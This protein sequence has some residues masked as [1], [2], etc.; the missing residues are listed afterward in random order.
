MSLLRRLLACLLLLSL[1]ACSA[2]TAYRP[3]IV[4]QH[5]LTLAYSDGV[6]I[7]AGRELLTEAPRFDGLSEYVHCVP[8]AV[9]HAEDAESAGQAATGLA[10]T[11][12][13]LGAGS[14]GGLSGL[15]FI[16]DEPATGYAILGTGIGVALIGLTMA[17]VSRAS[18]NQANGHAV[19]AL[20]YYNDAVG[21]RGK[22]CPQ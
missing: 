20:N 16:E 7:Y 9:E 11:G 3:R 15:A 12:I 4:A 17:I 5:E 19:D 22:R 18:K 8:R 21:S 2:A 14:L 10:V 1:S 13:V 6:Q